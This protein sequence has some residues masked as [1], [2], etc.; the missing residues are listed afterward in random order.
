[1][2]RLPAV[3]CV[4]MLP[5]SLPQLITATLS[6]RLKRVVVVQEEVEEEEEEEEEEE[7]VL[8]GFLHLM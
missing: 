4:N 5:P 8:Q 2:H 7:H 3:D 6:W 1:M